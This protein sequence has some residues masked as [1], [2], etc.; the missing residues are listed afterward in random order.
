MG[1]E[2]LDSRSPHSSLGE[3]LLVG[4]IVIWLR[5]VGAADVRV[6]VVHVVL[7][8]AVVGVRVYIVLSCSR[9]GKCLL[10]GRLPAHRGHVRAAIRAS[11]TASLVVIGRYRRLQDL[12]WT[13][14]V[15]VG[16]DGWALSTNIGSI[17]LRRQGRGRT[18]AGLR[19]LITQV[20]RD[21]HVTMHI[22]VVGVLAVHARYNVGRHASSRRKREGAITR[23][24]GAHLGI[25]LRE[26]VSIRA[27]CPAG[28]RGAGGECSSSGGSGL[29]DSSGVVILMAGQGGATRESLLAVGIRALVRPFSRMD[30][31]MP[32]QR[33]RITEGL[34]YWLGLATD[35]CRAS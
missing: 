3:P 12:G 32:C 23:R 18:R 13:V 26:L 33:A 1:V 19:H 27:A 4:I 22:G 20:R 15:R 7:A 16:S 2:L 29:L 24:R 31:A 30:A 25:G 8:A 35:R 5:A 11:R 9:R 34:R 6:A 28:S 10:R 14:S 17:G 21:I